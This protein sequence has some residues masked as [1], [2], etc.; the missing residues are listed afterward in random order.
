[1]PVFW[2]CHD[3]AIRL[4]HLIVTRSLDTIM[5]L[6]K[7]IS[8]LRTACYKE[9]RW[10]ERSTKTAAGGWLL[11]AVGAATAIPPLVILGAGTY[12]AGWSVGFFG[13]CSVSSKMRTKKKYMCELEERFPEL[14]SLHC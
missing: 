11:G 6:R 8:W 1:M 13:L 2:N 14:W 9:L 7:L 4:T 12:M 5:F 3:F 10:L